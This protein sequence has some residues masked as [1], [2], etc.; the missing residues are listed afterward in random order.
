MRAKVKD[1]DY[2][3]RDMNNNALLFI[4]KEELKEYKNKKQSLKK[5]QNLDKNYTILKKEM[6]ELKNEVKSILHLLK[7]NFKNEKSEND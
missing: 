6:F 4:N 2:L 5:I 1:K 3:E 7:E